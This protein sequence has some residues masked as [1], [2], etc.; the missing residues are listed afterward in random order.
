MCSMTWGHS[1]G[2]LFKPPSPLGETCGFQQTTILNFDM[3]A[4]L[5]TCISGGRA[6]PPGLNNTRGNVSSSL[7]APFASARFDIT[8][9]QAMRNHP[10]TPQGLQVSAKWGARVSRPPQ[11]LQLNTQWGGRASR[12]PQR[13]QLSTAHLLVYLL[14]YLFVYRTAKK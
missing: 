4:I 1:G 12:P 10:P 5:G 14:V 2:V 11:R 3:F 8:I 9:C 13:L 7:E 6:L